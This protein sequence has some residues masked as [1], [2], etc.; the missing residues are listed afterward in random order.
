MVVADLNLDAAA[1]VAAGLGGPDVAV[2]VRADVTDED[3]VGALVGAAVLAFGGVDLVVNNAGPVGLQAAAGDHG[4][5]LGPP[6]RRHGARV[7]PGLARGRAG[8]GRAGDGRRHRLHRL[9]ELAVRRPEQHRLLGDQGRPGPPGPAARRRARRARHPGQRRQPRRR[10]ARLG[11]LR[12]WLGGQA[13]RRVRR[14]GGGAGRVLRPAHPAQARGPAGARR[15]GG[16]RADRAGPGPDDGPAR[17]RSTPASRR[18]SCDDA[19]VRTGDAWD[20][21]PPST[22]AP[23]AVG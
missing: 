14:G 21:T 7:V 18:R 6:A 11:H 23:P 19:T 20:R 1:E 17:A 16:V 8:D 10:R 9:E 12:R 13:G 3:A 22:S 15:R 2:A 5:R 4:R